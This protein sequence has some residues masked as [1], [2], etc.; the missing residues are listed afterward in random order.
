MNTWSRERVRLAGWA[1]GLAV[2]TAVLVPLLDPYA[3]IPGSL[4][5]VAVAV[6]ALFSPAGIA[7]QVIVGLGLMGQ[8]L[9]GEVGPDPVLLAPVMAGVVA[10]AELLAAVAR[11]DTPVACDPDD[12]RPR[13]GMAAAVAAGVY[14]AVVLAAGIPGPTGLL[15]VVLASVAC[16]VLAMKFVGEAR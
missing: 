5:Y 1:I 6:G 11:M 8:L 3:R 12:A 15:A 10:T 4:L 16:G 2:A 14:G 7:V 13:T 9:L